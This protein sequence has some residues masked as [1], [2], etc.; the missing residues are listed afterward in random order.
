MERS[1]D[2]AGDVLYDG[3][4]YYSYDAEGRICAVQNYPQSGG[5]VAGGPGLDSETG[6]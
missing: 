3:V 5:T 6:D 2:A 1:C 4:N